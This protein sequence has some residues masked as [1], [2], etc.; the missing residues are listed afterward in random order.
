MEQAIVRISKG[1]F[2]ASRLG[3]VREL[4][5]KSLGPLQPAGMKFDLSAHSESHSTLW[6][7]A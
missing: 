7:I 4:I 2:D 1:H 6:K 3:E 5:A